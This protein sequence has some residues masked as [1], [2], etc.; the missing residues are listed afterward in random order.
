MIE[1]QRSLD[2]AWRRLRAD[3]T[4]RRLAAI[5]LRLRI[6]IALLALLVGAFVF[7]R[8][9]VAFASLAFSSGPSRVALAALVGWAMVVLAAATI[10][11]AHHARQ[12]GGMVA[13][14]A[15][16]SLPVSNRALLAHLAWESR[17]RA[18]WVAPIAPAVLAALVG[19]VPWW[20]IVGLA[21]LFAVLLD[22]AARLACAVAHLLR[23]GRSGDDVLVGLARRGSDSGRTTRAR[24]PG[25]PRWH[26]APRWRALWAKDLKITLRPTAARRRALLPIAFALVSF[27]SWTVSAEPGFARLLA[28]ATALLAAGTFGEWLIALAGEDPPTSFRA[29]PIGVGPLWWSRVAW[30][31]L[32]TLGIVAAQIPA[33]RTLSPQALELFLTWTAGATLLITLLA[34]HYG[35]TL[36]PRADVAQRLFSLTLGIAI[37]ASLMIPLLGWVTLLAALLHSARRLSRWDQLDPT[38]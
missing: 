31:G 11:A 8:A 34:V 7:W 37:V 17:L 13:G 14:P 16:R 22:G 19:L 38:S 5:E 33:A 9:R 30:C 4:R 35:I 10:V 29:L 36:Y 21:A 27:A 18:V 32:A 6:E 28:F 23:A 1:S 24:A 12:L 26:R 3:L 25:A 20:W 15:W 2:A